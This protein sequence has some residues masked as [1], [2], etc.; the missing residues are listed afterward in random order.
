MSISENLSRAI[1]NAGKGLKSL[2][3]HSGE[4]RKNMAVA[5]KNLKEFVSVNKITLLLAAIAAVKALIDKAK[6]DV[7]EAISKSD[8]AA[9]NRKEE[10]EKKSDD[11][12]RLDEL[13]SRYKELQRN[14]GSEVEN[15]AASRDI[16]KEIV[17]LLGQ[18]AN[19]LDLVNGRYSDQLNTL[20]KIKNEELKNAR[21][22]AEEAFKSAHANRDN[23]SKNNA[24]VHYDGLFGFAGEWGSNAAVDANYANGYRHFVISKGNDSD[25][26]AE[27]AARKL[28]NAGIYVDWINLGLLTQG[29]DIVFA[30]GLSP[31]EYKAQ[32]NEVLKV[33]EET[34]NELYTNARLKYDEIFGEE[35]YFTKEAESAR[36][37][38]EAHTEYLIA[39]QNEEETISSF[40]EY[41]AMRDKLISDLLSDDSVSKVLESGVLTNSDI[42]SIIDKSL[43]EIE[44][45]S[46]YQKQFERKSIVDLMSK[47]ESV[48]KWLYGLADAQ[49]QQLVSMWRE[50]SKSYF[51]ALG[52]DQTTAEFIN[53]ILA[54]APDWLVPEPTSTIDML[55][56]NHPPSFFYDVS[57]W[58]SRLTQETKN[59]DF[60]GSLMSK[61]SSG[62]SSAFI[63]SIDT[64]V[65]KVQAL[66]EALQK[67]NDGSLSASDKKSLIETYPELIAYTDDLGN[68]ITTLL[69][70]MNT[71]I[72]E[73]F[74]EKIDIV[75][76]TLSEGESSFVE[77]KSKLE[78]VV[79]AFNTIK[80]AIDDYNESGVLSID[81]M[82]SIL[83]LDDKYINALT[84]ERGE[85]DL[86]AE[87]YK[88]LVE[89]EAIE[90][91]AQVLQESL[92]TVKNI[93]DRAGA[94]EYLEGSQKDAAQASLTLA[95]AQWQEAY[96]AA[97]VRDATEGTGDLYKR[98][99][100][101]ARKAYDVRVSLIDEYLRGTTIVDDYKESLEDEKKALED[102]KSALEDQKKALEETKS[103]YEDALS[104]VK[105]LVGWV[106]DYIKQIK[107]DEIDALQEKKD[108]IDKLI[109]AQKE[110]I[111]AE[112]E[113]YEWNKKISE[114]QNTVAKDAL[115]A[116]IASLDDSSAGRKAQKQ[117]NDKLAESR[118]DMYDTLYDHEIEIRK[119]ALDKLKEEQDEYYD[120]QIKE[121]QDYLSDEV[122]LYKDACAMIDNDSGELYG[123][124]L[125]YCRNHTTT[126]EAEF[127]HMWGSAKAALQQYN[128]ANLGTFDLLNNLQGSIYRV[129]AA[130]DTVVESISSYEDSIAGV[131]E[132]IDS[133]GQSAQKTIA[134]I[135]AAVDAE[136]EWTKPRWAYK[137]DGK[138]YYSYHSIKDDAVADIRKQLSMKYGNSAFVLG[139]VHAGAVKVNNKYASGTNSA[140]GGLSLVGERGAELRVLNR[141]DG[142]LTNKIT[143]G[144]AALGANPSQF[145]ADAGK[146]LLSSL[147]GNSIKPSF[148]AIGTGNN[149]PI[150]IVNHIQ[151]DVN[152]STLKALVAAQKKIVQESV[153]AV[154]KQSLSL[155]PQNSI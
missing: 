63:K 142:I 112:K 115:A 6:R 88:K 151:G 7:E 79:S 44:G 86:S 55:A 101:A 78:D 135:K 91:K 110:L 125:W 131:Q 46:E 23:A 147:F 10:A 81:N 113:E 70:G 61:D 83:A 75:L 59:F 34:S 15:R 90:L 144:L 37:F 140:S 54:Y 76:N 26:S 71:D 43:S 2:V 93:A 27:E 8:E 128:T 66:K 80:S 105:D 136:N 130:I 36:A 9:K 16:Q 24:S 69:Q 45:Y 107:N 134:G 57:D 149:Q 67:L 114:K 56:P 38:A 127:N 123:K 126:T 124:L 84:N 49:F 154:Q 64:T 99:V 68:G 111:D 65:E 108:T 29:F 137:F 155:R 117:A 104:A 62:K 133:L 85:I 97:A 33:L 146:K 12:K 150:S 14:G 122:R 40:E 73:K 87:S 35:G 98:T 152:P 74:N 118:S 96:A 1:W 106:Q 3:T 94:L 52:R 153:R 145:I 11:V 60:F 53:G 42:S 48:R 25:Q 100:V 138:T 77:F 103:G 28:K 82:R 21:D 116:S 58:M 72:V 95:D 119:D 109:D 47:D 17:D 121:I 50:E 143:Q 13:I 132:K 148:S 39:T 41:L 4:F 102:S 18:Q 32:W 51:E 141:N 5:L 31:S 89:A 139:Q 120:N 20:K 92:N 129:D 30:G 22:A 19:K